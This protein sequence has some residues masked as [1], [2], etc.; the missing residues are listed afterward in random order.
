MKFRGSK[1]TGTSL[2][3]VLGVVCFATILVAAAITLSNTLTIT[4]TATDGVTIGT[5][6]NFVVFDAGT[7]NHDNLID[8][9]EGVVT[10]TSYDFG[11]PVVG[12][13]TSAGNIVITVSG[14]GI[15]SGS[16][17]HLYYWNDDGTPDWEAVSGSVTTTIVFTIPITITSESVT[18]GFNI[19]FGNSGSF[20]V[21][22]VVTN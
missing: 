10:N 17:A 5:S 7:P 4:K 19:D 16:S 11:I 20:T 1:I 12:A 22:A 15:V 9:T 18:H 3:T 2:L 8:M 21:S 13:S 14:T 6:D